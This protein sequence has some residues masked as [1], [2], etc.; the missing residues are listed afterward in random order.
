MCCPHLQVALPPV[1]QHGVL[2]RKDKRV[3][4]GAHVPE[5]KAALEQVPARTRV[6]NAHDGAEQPFQQGPSV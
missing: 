4:P 6:Y 5:L 2:G 1:L 3:A